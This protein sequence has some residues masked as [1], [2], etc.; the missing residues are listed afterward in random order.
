LDNKST[1]NW[2]MRK[3]ILKAGGI[4]R[5][6]TRKMENKIFANVRRKLIV[7]TFQF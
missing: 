2:W 7:A 4:R 6:K 1:S 5:S 3:L